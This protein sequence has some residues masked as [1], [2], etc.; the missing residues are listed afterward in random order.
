MSTLCKRI[1]DQIC[2][3]AHQAG[4]GWLPIAFV[5]HGWR[6]RFLPHDSAAYQ[7]FLSALSDFLRLPSFQ[8]S[9]PAFPELRPDDRMAM[10][11][12]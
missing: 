3:S 1:A 8:S 6:F 9:A 5:I 12:F 4:L 7:A 10:N 11:P 2:G